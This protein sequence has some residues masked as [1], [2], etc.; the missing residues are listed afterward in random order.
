M[1][2]VLVTRPDPGAAET[3]AA[4]AGRGHVPI[5]APL[6]TIEPVPGPALDLTGYDAV[7]VTSANGVRALAGRSGRRDLPLYAVGGRT[8]ALARDLGFARVHSADGDVADLSRRLADAGPGRVLHVAGADL[9]GDL[10][11]AG[12][13][14]T[15]LTAYRAV[16]AAALPDTALAALR[17]GQVAYVTL[18]SPRTAA[19]FVRLAEKAGLSPLAGDWTAL[20]L[21]AAVAQAAAGFGFADR[22]IAA[23][24][25][26][27]SL[28]ALLPAV[29]GS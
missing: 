21:S 11:P 7:A 1:T 6:L 4:I 22:R 13:E 12:V 18:F 19:S 2:G 23:R 9:A 10:T 28:L 27:A 24:P 8:A 14:V 15:R 29:K 25:D 16:E 26:A 17:N 5:L 3:A 20:C